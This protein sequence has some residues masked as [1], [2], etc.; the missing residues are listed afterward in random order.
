MTDTLFYKKLYRLGDD[1]ESWDVISSVKPTS[2]SSKAPPSAAIQTEYLQATFNKPEQVFSYSVDT[3]TVGVDGD[4]QHDTERVVFQVLSVI[5]PQ[6][7]P[8]LVPT[9]YDDNDVVTSA[10]VAVQLQ[11]LEVWGKASDDRLT[12]YF[13]SDPEYKNTHDVLPFFKVAAESL[14]VWETQVSD[15]GNCIDLLS[16]NAQ[17]RTFR[18]V[19]RRACLGTVAATERHGLGGC[20][21]KDRSYRRVGAFSGPSY[22]SIKADV[23]SMLATAA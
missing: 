22:R 14:L 10:R 20:F 3:E 15:V 17:P 9:A 7:R 12:C 19:E 21:Q 8:K 2:A 6:S 18:C 11:Y 4:V 13:E 1:Y 23:L 5:T 16:P